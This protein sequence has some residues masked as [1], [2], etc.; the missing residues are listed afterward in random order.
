MKV[1]SN[2]A[3]SEW[4]KDTT[5]Y[6]GQD[7]IILGRLLCGMNASLIDRISPISV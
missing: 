3:A 5:N 2:R 1:L 7:L 6:T 4:K